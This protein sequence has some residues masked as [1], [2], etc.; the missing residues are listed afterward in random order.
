MDENNIVVLVG[1][2]L[3]ASEYGY[4]NGFVQYHM[5][6]IKNSD[7][8]DEYN[9]LLKTA[10][11]KHYSKLHNNLMKKYQN[12][13]P[14]FTFFADARFLNL[15]QYFSFLALYKDAMK[16][17]DEELEA[18]RKADAEKAQAAYDAEYARKKAELDGI[19]CHLKVVAAPNDYNMDADSNKLRPRFASFLAISN[20][21]KVLILNKYHPLLETEQPK[22]Q[23]LYPNYRIVLQEP[24]YGF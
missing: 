20:E 4:A 18:K 6:I 8:L 10:M 13:P 19:W 5:S 1:Q 16:V 22:M 2:V 24:A 3:S 12:K 14:F 11:S 21:E 9:K 7:E 23:E 17:S 15:Q